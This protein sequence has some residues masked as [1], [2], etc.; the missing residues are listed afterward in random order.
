MK[1]T[2]YNIGRNAIRDARNFNQK[3]VEPTA[4]H[5]PNFDFTKTPHSQIDAIE[6]EKQERL[7]RQKLLVILEQLKPFYFNADE[8]I[9]CVENRA[10]DK[11]DIYHTFFRLWQ[12]ISYVLA[13]NT[14]SDDYNKDSNFE[15]TLNFETYLSCLIAI[16]AVIPLAIAIAQAI[17]EFRKKRELQSFAYHNQRTV[18]ANPALAESDSPVHDA[19]DRY[20]DFLARG[21]VKIPTEA[22]PSPETSKLSDA[23]KTA[24]EIDNAIKNREGNLP[25][26]ILKVALDVIEWTKKTALIFWP[27]FMTCMLFVGITAVYASPALPF[28]MLATALLAV[29]FG[30]SVA[31]QHYRDKRGIVDKIVKEKGE[32]TEDA[33]KRFRTEVEQDLKHA[34]DEAKTMAGMKKLLFQRDHMKQ[35]HAYFKSIFGGDPIKPLQE[36]TSHTYSADANG[37]NSELLVLIP[38]ENLDPAKKEVPEKA[39]M[40][41]AEDA[42]YKRVQES[43]LYRR[44][45][46]SETKQ[47]KL[48]FGKKITFKQDNA[49]II[50]NS[51]FDFIGK[52]TLTAFVL[53]LI[54]ATIMAIALAA[55]GAISSAVSGVLSVLGSGG[56]TF[57]LGTGVSLL[58]AFRTFSTLKAAQENKKNEVMHRLLEKYEGKAIP[59]VNNKF[60]AFIHF[61]KLVN[62]QKE[63]FKDRQAKLQGVNRFAEDDAKKA[64]H[65]LSYDLKA[66]DVYNDHYFKTQKKQKTFG[67]KVYQVFTY[68]YKMVSVAQTGGFIVRTLFLTGAGIAAGI[69]ATLILGNPIAFIAIFA[70]TGTIFAAMKFA[71]VYLKQR[72]EDQNSFDVVT[73]TAFLKKQLK[74]LTVMNECADKLVAGARSDAQAIAVDDGKEMQKKALRSDDVRWLAAK[75]PATSPSGLGRGAFGVSP[76]DKAQNSTQNIIVNLPMNKKVERAFLQTKT[77]SAKQAVAVSKISMF[78]GCTAEMQAAADAR[79]SSALTA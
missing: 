24:A 59:G 41:D 7:K 30:L 3:R 43:A 6:K 9:D 67:E 11:I 46:S 78:G 76:S 53:W 23:E 19:L 17:Y 38:N 28:V 75:T 56:M 44:M 71:H 57:G 51:A 77:L 68:A 65:I 36:N 69:A 15:K 5:D 12:V 22:P 2:K 25:A 31:I 10:L 50:L 61:E 58:S 16:G 37:E 64:M 54:S 34:S 49:S 72:E 26:T 27:I 1:E 32:M 63:I 39:K 40:H 35:A 74:E 14:N 79:P 73:R 48:P 8:I 52:Y 4:A 21:K 33:K 13:N 18:E 55:A 47:I 60:E 70:I 20:N 29:G 42:S 45:T 62:A 66:N